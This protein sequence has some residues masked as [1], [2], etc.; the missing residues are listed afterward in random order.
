MLRL[1]K[2]ISFANYTTVKSIENI[3]NEDKSI[4]FDITT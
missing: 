3:E 4:S 1:I 2:D